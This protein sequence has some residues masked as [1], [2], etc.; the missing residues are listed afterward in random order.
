M[1]SKRTRTSARGVLAVV[2]LAAAPCLGLDNGLGLRPQM[3]YNSWYDLECTA[4][5]NE[6]TIRAT[7]RAMKTSGAFAFASSSLPLRLLPWD[8]TPI[9]D[10][11]TSTARVASFGWTFWQVGDPI[12]LTPLTAS[13]VPGRAQGRLL[14]QHP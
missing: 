1:E 12:Q 7:A 10:L 8:A 11:R 4:S 6:T 3:G 5:M 2:A 13:R 9:D 14:L